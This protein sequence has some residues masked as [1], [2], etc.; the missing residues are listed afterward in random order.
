MISRGE[1]HVNQPLIYLHDAILQTRGNTQ[2]AGLG[3]QREVRLHRE[4]NVETHNIRTAH[5]VRP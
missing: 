5:E 4:G 1:V 2:F 3:L